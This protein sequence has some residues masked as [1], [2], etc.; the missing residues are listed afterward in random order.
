[1]L[2]MEKSTYMLAN[3]SLYRFQTITVLSICLV[4][5][6]TEIVKVSAFFPTLD[7]EQLDI[8]KNESSSEKEGEKEDKNEKEYEKD[9]FIPKNYGQHP[10]PFYDLSHFSL[11]NRYPNQY[12][13]TP[14]LPPEA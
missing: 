12:L 4:I 11:L 2:S 9:H 7:I 8:T 6:C 1:V 5:F 14:Y 13:E 3:Q 10:F